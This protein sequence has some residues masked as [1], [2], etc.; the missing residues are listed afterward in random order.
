M[1]EALACGVPVVAFR[2]GSVA[3][4]IDDGVTGFVV[5]TVDE[6]IDA[7]RNVANLSRVNCRATFER[8]FSVTR[9]AENYLQVYE[10]QLAA[11]AAET[12]L[13]TTGVA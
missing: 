7:T 11:R 10:S 1:I 5:D 8:R 12:S 6:A 2:G 9:M 3:E 4:V 13:M